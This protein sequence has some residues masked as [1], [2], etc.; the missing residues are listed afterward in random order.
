MGRPKSSTKD[1]VIFIRCSEE[2][3]RSWRVFTAKEGF[4]DYE[5]ALKALMDVYEWVKKRYGTVEVVI[6]RNK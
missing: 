1:R 2:T 3:Y 5:K 6:P 4:K